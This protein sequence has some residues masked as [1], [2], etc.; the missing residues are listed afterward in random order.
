MLHTFKRKTGI[1]GEV[2]ILTT[3]HLSV[4]DLLLVA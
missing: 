3:Q 4:E 2:S 1:D